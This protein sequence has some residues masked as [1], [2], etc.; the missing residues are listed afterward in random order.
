MDSAASTKRLGRKYIRGFAGG[1]AHK[2]AA[3]AQYYAWLAYSHKKPIVTID[4]IAMT[5]EPPL[6]DIERNRI[7]AGY[8]HKALLDNT[9]SLAHPGTVVSAMLTANFG[10]QDLIIDGSS[11]TIGET[12]FSVVLTDDRGKEWTSDF[13]K[14]RMSVAIPEEFRTDFNNFEGKL[15]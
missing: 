12:T 10:I 13:K 7:L 11:A 4:L 5:I 9:H 6:F 8:C 3:S 1:I 14:S 15:G 2:F